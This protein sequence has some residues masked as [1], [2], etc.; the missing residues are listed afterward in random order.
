[1]SK[2]AP[3]V[4]YAEIE[5]ESS[6]TRVQVVLDLDGGTRRDI[7]TGIRTFDRLLGVL[8]F[9]GY[10]DIGV[11]V[12]HFVMPADDHNALEGVGAAFGKAIRTALI[13]S[14]SIERSATA[15]EM[16]DESLVA[17]TIDL[18]GRSHLT[19]NF[20]LTR[21]R[22][23]DIA[24]ESVKEFFV[25]LTQF[26]RFGLHIRTLA[27]DNNHHLLEAVF[28]AFGVALHRASRHAER[29]IGL[30]IQKS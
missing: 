1:M 23:G 21:E 6:E 8:A 3:T 2:G 11:E 25:A 4:R 27:G 30:L 26:G 10:M 18:S 22:V 12:E 14:D 19:Y 17:V 20:E 15:T 28:K 5:R 13:D 24:S 29:R 16:M 7:S 9:Y